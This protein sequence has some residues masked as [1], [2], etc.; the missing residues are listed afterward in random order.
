MVAGVIAA[1]RTP[2]GTLYIIPTA[3]AVAAGLCMIAMTGPLPFYRCPACR[4]RLREPTYLAPDE[5]HARPIHFVCPRCDIQWDTG[6]KHGGS[7]GV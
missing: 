2:P 5:D 1:Y 7:V 6:W 3:C 4:L